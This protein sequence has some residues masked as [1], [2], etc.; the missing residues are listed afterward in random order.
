MNIE[1]EFAEIFDSEM[2]AHG[3]SRTQ[4]VF[5]RITPG[6]MVQLVS[7]IKYCDSYTVQYMN[8][9][10]CGGFEFSLDFDEQRLSEGILCG[11]ITDDN[12]ETLK[13]ALEACKL[14]ILPKL[15]KISDYKNYYE[16]TKHFYKIQVI[17]SRLDV[18]C[19]NPLFT[20]IVSPAFYNISMQL[21]DFEMPQTAL[22][23]MFKYY[24]ID[25]DTDPS[26]WRGNVR[27]LYELIEAHKHG[28]DDY[29]K[30]SIEAD[31]ARSLESYKQTFA[32]VS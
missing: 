26:S 18:C 16:E 7:Y 3:F 17:C 22:E 23:N 21:G 11:E 1:N 28:D 25:P 27:K 2:K 29:I 6:K 30:N 12:T 24:E 8:R 19:P 31:E 13:D 5:H 4:A 20:G 15:D 14:I 10:L 32:A 9:P